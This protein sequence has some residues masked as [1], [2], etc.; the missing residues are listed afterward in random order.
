M[1][2]WP[3]PDAA[4]QSWYLKSDG[5]ANMGTGDGVLTQEPSDRSVD[6]SYIYN[7]REPVPTRGGPVYWGLE[8]LGPVDQ[9]PLLDRS[10]LLFYRGPKLE[11][12]LTVVG[13]VTLDLCI[14]SDAPRYRFC[15]QTLC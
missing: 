2:D 4:T 12:P 10:D 13:E 3:P 15:C 7:P 6:D 14:S 1:Q 11:S 9:R 8:H 5:S